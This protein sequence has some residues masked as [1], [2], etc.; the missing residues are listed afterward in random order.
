MIT[1]LELTIIVGALT[2]FVGFIVVWV[3]YITRSVNK[4][5]DQLAQAF[6]AINSLLSDRVEEPSEQNPSPHVSSP[7]Q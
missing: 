3:T 7:L 5:R 2:L 4:L 1:L 6:D